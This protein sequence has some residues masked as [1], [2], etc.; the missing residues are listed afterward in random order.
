MVPW[1]LAR[2]AKPGD[3]VIALG[4][5]DVNKVLSPVAADIRARAGKAA[6]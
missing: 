6:P 3:V 5:G 1:E 2:L 4:A